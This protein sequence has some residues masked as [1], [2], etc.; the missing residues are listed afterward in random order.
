MTH[1]EIE[2]NL[3]WYLNGTLSPREIAR[4]DAE[5]ATC[6]RC[7]ASA[8]EL[9]ALRSALLDIERDA[10]ET[11]SAA[12]F[13]TLERRIDSPSPSR[14]RSWWT[15][16]W[17]RALGG[18]AT[19]AIVAALFFGPHVTARVPATMP[20]PVL[21]SAHDAAPAPEAKVAAVAHDAAGAGKLDATSRS[22]RQ[23][24]RMG[25]IGLLVADVPAAIAGGER[26]A[27]AN[28]GVV[29]G[30]QDDA[31]S[32]PAARHTAHVTL[33]VPDDRFSATIADLA[34]LGGVTARSVS[35]ED[36]TDSIVDT[37]ARLRNL[38]R[39]E[40]DLLRI[41]DRSGKV[42][43]I[44]DVEQQL[45]STREEIERLD[46]ESQSMRRRVAYATIAVDLADEKTA[47]VAAP[48]A[49]SQ[50]S[51]AWDAA[52]RRVWAFTLSLAAHA[53]VLVA[54]APYL[55]VAGIAGYVGYVAI[56]RK[57]QRL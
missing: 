45:A 52:K 41:M 15:R 6:A 38:R 19:C 10:P 47:S 44:L 5:L 55:A 24:A 49:G 17:P 23:L 39:E 18:L 53:L 48:S 21:E 4:I 32:S 51:A 27:A 29:T 33:S 14:S 1:A 46:A 26:I 2:Q 3:P 40:S 42:A 43:D 54:F 34:K 20:E 22:A 11:A 57:A 50:M 13:A 31:P 12:A 8:A 25:S 28:F 37:A 30:L 7:A 56:R 36:L 16:P 35:T 9:R